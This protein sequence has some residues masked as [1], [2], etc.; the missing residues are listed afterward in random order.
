M[1]CNCTIILMRRELVHGEKSIVK[2]RIK[3][4]LTSMQ[5][6]LNVIIFLARPLYVF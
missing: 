1:F 6:G 3:N 2:R 5:R 4:Y